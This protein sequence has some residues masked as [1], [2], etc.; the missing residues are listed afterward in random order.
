MYVPSATRP[1]A[2]RQ[3]LQRCEPS[4]SVHSLIHRKQMTLLEGQG[5]LHG[6]REHDRMHPELRHGDAAW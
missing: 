4:P 2:A 5:P 3:R 6:T 1:A